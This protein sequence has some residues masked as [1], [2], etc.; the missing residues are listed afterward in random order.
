MI[1]VTTKN[2]IIPIYQIDTD[3]QK[4][5][6]SWLKTTDLPTEV[7]IEFKGM[8]YRFHSLAERLRW[9]DGFLKGMEILEQ[10]DGDVHD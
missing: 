3:D 4:E 8:S 10:K 7:I 2:G 1:S 9:I 6:V 5:L